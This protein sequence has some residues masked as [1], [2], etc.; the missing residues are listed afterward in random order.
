MDVFIASGIF[1]KARTMQY[2]SGANV[3][4]DEGISS[5]PG[6]KGV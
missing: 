5:G 6:G 4:E 1:W 3:G 2:P